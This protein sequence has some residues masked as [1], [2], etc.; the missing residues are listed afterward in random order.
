MLALVLGARL[1]AAAAPAPTEQDFALIE[2]GRYL[3]TAADCGACHTDPASGR[4]FAGGRP[5]ET[6]FGT[7]IAPNIT[8]DPDT[9]IG[10]WS[11]AQFD[12]ALREGK[13]PD[14]SRLYPAMPYVYYTRMTRADVLAIRAYL[15]SVA[16]VHNSVVSDQLPFPFN[17]RASLWFWDELYFTP[18]EFKPRTGQSAEWNRGAY[19]VEGP[20][21][22][23]ACHTPKTALGGDD[24]K[25][26]L[27]GYALQGW[28]SPNLTN[29]ARLGLGHW[30]SADLIQYLK[31]GHNRFAAASGPMAEEV[32]D[33]SSQM[34]DTDLAAIAAYL[35]D[36]APASEDTGPSAPPAGDP[37][38]TAG[39][40]IYDDLCSA[41][42]KPDGTGIPYL[43]PN[44][45]DAG[46]VAAR[47]PT[48]LMRVVLRGTRSVA[49]A[50]EP[51]APA[52]PE[53]GSQLSDAQIAAVLT[54]IRGSW[55][56]AAPGVTEAEVR[57]ARTT[58]SPAQ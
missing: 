34:T 40:A 19:L 10:S 27:G 58:M 6:P 25:R 30:S 52:M 37:R 11:D 53:Y 29:D 35:K 33:S 26:A 12:A 17:I 44:L 7:V 31:S 18:G 3:A 38:M 23:G 56:H 51:T 45:A 4:P 36:H 15:K 9:G 2:R 39:A 21:H 13:L 47:E 54:Y 32:A 1:A 55:G 22:C 28:F 50:A 41:C 43:I 24:A 42:H 49:T 20:G 46:S 5:I 48:T 8:P 14:G 57:K 16:A